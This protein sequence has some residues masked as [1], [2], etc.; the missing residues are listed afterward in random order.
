MIPPALTRVVLRALA[1]AGEASP[2]R[3]IEPVKGGMVSTS[4]RIVTQR[5]SYLLKYHENPKP[6]LYSCEQHGM[7]LLRAA[8][9]RVPAVIAAAD[10]TEETPGYCIQEWIHP[11]SMDAQRRRLNAELAAEIAQMHQ[12]EAR[13]PGYGC[14]Y[15]S[16]EGP[17]GECW[18]ED[19]VV[20]FREHRLRCYVELLTRAGRMPPD[21]RE[22][23]ERLIESLPERL[24]G[25]ERRPSLLHGDL[26]QRNIVANRAGQSVLIDPVAFY[27]DREFETAY[28]HLW[29]FFP[30]L[31]WQA[32]EAA[33]P[34]DAGAKERRD[35]YLVS[36]LL[37]NVAAGMVQLSQRLDVTLHK[38]VGYRGG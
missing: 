30:P 7:E 9:M 4:W 27:G 25:A 13:V 38:C 17:A 20:Y 35:V 24:G 23:L 33:Y 21:R 36:H 32:Y 18:E 16:T 6:F 12:T 1:E 31:F 26:H 14:S 10:R 34:H 2:I 29:G 22:A 11:G 19:W 37:Q 28:M 3:R 5:R 15:T 8:G